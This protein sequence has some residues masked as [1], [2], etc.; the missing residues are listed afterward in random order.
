M[1]NLKQA[2]TLR[3]ELVANVSHDLRT[4]LATLQ[5]Y[6]ETLLLKNKRLSEKD[7]K[8][9]LEIAIQ[10]CQRLSNLVDELFELA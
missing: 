6:I 2:D 5:G 3:R 10:H 8:H 4:P 9:H 1:E 7:R